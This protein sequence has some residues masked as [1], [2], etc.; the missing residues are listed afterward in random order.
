MLTHA[1]SNLTRDVLR[2]IVAAAKHIFG[3]GRM[4]HQYGRKTLG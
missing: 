1:P 2:V 3:Q 4:F